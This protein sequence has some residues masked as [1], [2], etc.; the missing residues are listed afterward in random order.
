M[1][2]GYC[3]AMR[4]IILPLRTLMV[5]AVCCAATRQASAQDAMP[6]PRLT[7]E[8]DGAGSALALIDRAGSPAVPVAVRV[9]LQAPSPDA[10]TDAQLGN[11]QQ[12]RIPV[13]LSVPAPA[14]AADLDAWRAALKRTIDRRATT[15]AVLEIVVDRQPPDV[16]A[17][18]VRVAA[19][20]ARAS[21]ARVRL[22]LG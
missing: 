16:A 9:I 14:T 17:F 22:A 2:P 15:L 5:V 11:L 12:R 18:A 20:E 10:S 4:G 7:I 1:E 13:W 19:T 6:L 3:R 8:D 21:S